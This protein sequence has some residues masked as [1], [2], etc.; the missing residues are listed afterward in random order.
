MVERSNMTK[1]LEYVKSRVDGAFEDSTAFDKELIQEI[2]VA[3]GE[4]S[5]LVSVNHDVEITEETLFEDVLNVESS[6]MPHCKTY[7]GINVR[8]NF[9]P[10]SGSLM[11]VL[12]NAKEHT[13]SRIRIAEDLLRE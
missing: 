6:V 1:I 8:I 13:A 4:L 9:D 12:K 11:D 5:L 7:I 3:L 10:P 2:E